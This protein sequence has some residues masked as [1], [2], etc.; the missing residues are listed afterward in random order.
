MPT[1]GACRNCRYIVQ[2][3]KVCPKCGGDISEKYSGM[4]IILNPEKSEVAKIAEV[5]TVGS[6]AVKVK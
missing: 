6:Y 4:V 1:G 3:E 2:S 5:N